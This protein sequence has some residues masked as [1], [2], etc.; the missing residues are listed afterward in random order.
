MGAQIDEVKRLKTPGTKIQ[1]AGT[2]VFV[3]I[4]YLF[5]LLSCDVI[6]KQKAWQ[7]DGLTFSGEGYIFMLLRHPF[8]NRATRLN[9]LGPGFRT[10]KSE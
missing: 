10:L 6:D 4:G 5:I 7:N 8:Q 1:T 3:A 2:S 9:S